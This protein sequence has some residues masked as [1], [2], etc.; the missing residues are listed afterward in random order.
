M[1]TLVSPDR[2]SFGALLKGEKLKFSKTK[3][4]IVFAL[5]AGLNFAI[6][7]AAH[8]GGKAYYGTGC[9]NGST[10]MLYDAP[11]GTQTVTI[12][13]S[14]RNKGTVYE[15]FAYTG[16]NQSQQLSVSC[17]GSLTAWLNYLGANGRLLYTRLL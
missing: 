14:R 15:S 5:I 9:V 1:K 2:L 10:L 17:T 6:V 8:A 4:A 11:A 12:T 13:S 3:I 7:P 16:V